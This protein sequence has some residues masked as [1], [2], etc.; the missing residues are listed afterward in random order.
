MTLLLEVGEGIEHFVEGEDAI[1]YGANV[2]L[3]HGAHHHHEVGARAD[4]YPLQ[5]EVPHD[6]DWQ[7]Q[8]GRSAGEHADETER[9]AMR[10]ARTER[11][12][13]PAAG[14]SL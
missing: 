1:D 6:D 7:R 5:P 8:L 10:A 2:V 11:S 14:S 12:S 4:R 9:A 3:G 13:V